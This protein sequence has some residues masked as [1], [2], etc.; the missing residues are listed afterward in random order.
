MAIKIRIV[1]MVLCFSSNGWAGVYKCIDATGNSHYQ[2][3]PCDEGAQALEIDTKTGG[4]VDL[5]AL[6]SQRA[7]VAKQKEQQEAQRNAE[8][9]ARLD[10]I[11]LRKKLAQEQDE[12]T[13]AMIKQNPT[14]FSAFAIPPYD[15]HKLPKLVKPFEERLPDIEKFRRLAAQKA[16][17]TG[18]CQ[19][20][21]SDELNAKSLKEQLV[22]MVNCS[23]GRTYYYNESELAE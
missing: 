16:L 22:F 7:L 17:A 8:E 15:P 13:Q 10:V 9:K 2:S 21:E 4:Q 3:S 14:R 1:L 5:D 12:L 11:V 18:D 19:R 20:V 23:S 6:E